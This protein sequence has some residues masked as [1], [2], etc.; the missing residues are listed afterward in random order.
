[1]C[2]FS[3][4]VIWVF[5][6]WFQSLCCVSSVFVLCDLN[7]WYEI[8]VPYDFKSCDVWFES[9][10]LSVPMMW[11]LRPSV[12]AVC[13]F[14]LC[15]IQF[16]WCVISGTQVAAPSRAWRH[17][18]WRIATKTTHP[19]KFAPYRYFLG[20]HSFLSAKSGPSYQGQATWR[21]V[22]LE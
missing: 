19:S 15:G 21:R 11:D 16:L 17:G 5:D 9:L 4:R 13:D 6:V 14:S 22:L 18:S 20:L 1:M 3:P 8:S 7:L 10:W 12:T 2:D